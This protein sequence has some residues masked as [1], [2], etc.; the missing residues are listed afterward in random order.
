M[1]LGSSQQAI[2][3]IAQIAQINPQVLDNLNLDQEVRDIAEAYGLDKRVVYEIEE[4]MR[5]RQARAQQAAQQQQAAMQL[6]A[7]DVQS[8]AL[9]NASKAS[10]ELLSKA[11]LGPAV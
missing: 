6:Q 8:K 3:E 5:T 7:M 11:G 10:P 9:A 2:M 4:V 1:T